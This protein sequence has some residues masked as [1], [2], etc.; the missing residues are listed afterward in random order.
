MSS[1]NF[2]FQVS[3]LS[4]NFKFQFQV[5]ISKF[6]IKFQVQVLISNFNFKFQFHVSVSC[7]SFKFKFQVSIK[8]R[9]MFKFLFKL[10][11]LGFVEAPVGVFPSILT[12][13][14]NL[15]LE[16]FGASRHLKTAIMQRAVKVT[17]IP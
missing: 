15:I 5:S 11:F 7:F 14:V 16:L 6:N 17:K 3:I 4:F 1:F 13:N 2:K 9:F 12:L 8:I 10:K